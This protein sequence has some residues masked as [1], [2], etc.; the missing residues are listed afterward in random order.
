MSTPPR[1]WCGQPAVHTLG[2]YHYC[3]AHVQEAEARYHA[4]AGQDPARRE[5]LAE[6]GI[7]LSNH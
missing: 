2:S 3:T 4:W 5:R 1:C 7:R 6:L